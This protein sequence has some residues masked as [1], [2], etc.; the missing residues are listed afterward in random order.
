MIYYDFRDENSEEFQKELLFLTNDVPIV[1][2]NIKKTT[3]LELKYE[4]VMNREN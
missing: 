1:I 2:S 4:G 3:E